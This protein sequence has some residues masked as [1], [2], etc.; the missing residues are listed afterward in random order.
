MDKTI[1]EL[2]EFL[3]NKEIDEQEY[4]SIIETIYKDL[5]KKRFGL[6]WEDKTENSHIELLGHF[7]LLKEDKNKEIIKNK[8]EKV[9]LLMEGDNLFALKILQYTHKNSIDLVIIDPPYNRGKKDFRYNDEWVAADDEWRHSKW[10]SF[11]NKRLRLTRDILKDDGIIIISID[12]NELYNLKLLCDSVFGEQNFVVNIPTIMNLKGNQ[13]QYGFAGCHEYT[14]VYVKDKSKATFGSFDV[15]EEALEEWKV[16][17][18]GYYKKGAA[19]KSTGINAPREK[20]KNLYYPIMVDNDMNVSTV[21]KEEFKDIYCKSSNSFD[22]DYVEE[23]KEKYEKEG[24]KVF[25]PKSQKS[26]DS[27]RWERKKVEVENYNIIVSKDKGKFTLYKKQRPQI[28]DLPTKKPKS[29]FYKPE[30]SSGNATVLMKLMF[31]G[32]KIFENP[33]PVELIKDLIKIGSNKYSLIL[34]Y[35][36]GSGTTGQAVLELN[37]EDG[38]NRSFILCNNTEGDN[39]CEAVTYKRLKKVIEGYEYENGKNKKKVI[40]PGLEGNLKYYKI[41]DDTRIEEDIDDN[42]ESL[43]EKCTDLISVKECCFDKIKNTSEYDIVESD[44]K[45]VLICKNPLIMKYEVDKLLTSTIVN[46]KKEK[47]IYTT[48]SDYKYEGVITRDF[49]IEIINRLYTPKRYFDGCKI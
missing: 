1:K 10:L 30:Y 49:P 9:N 27:W 13:D 26:L 23:L 31:D 8:N 25:L 47:I 36:A 24:Y 28:G 20:R 22:D 48:F 12:D 18:I 16:D 14:L 3:K 34:D 45:I 7:P 21:T 4:I 43:I 11:M 44:T 2:Q 42:I 33:K 35:F 17:S 32:K 40:V 38:G 39:I 29:F 5:N 6:H 15:D 41:D 37:K 19:L 46:S